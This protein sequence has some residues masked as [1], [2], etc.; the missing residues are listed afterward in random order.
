[1]TTKVMEDNL[2][3][4]QLCHNR[5]GDHGKQSA[6]KGD[7]GYECGVFSISQAEDGAV[8]G[9]RHGDD[10][11]VDV[12]HQRVET[13]NAED[14]I[15]D[16]WED[17]QPE[18][19]GGIYHSRTEHRVPGKPR[20]RRTYDQQ[21]SRHGDVAYHGDGLTDDFWNVVN[22]QRHNQDGKIGCNHW[23]AD[24]HLGLERQPLLF[25]IHQ[26]HSYGKDRE[27]VYYIENGGI[28]YCLVAEN[29]IHYGV[30]Y[31][32]YISEHQGEPHRPSVFNAMGEKPW[33]KPCYDRKQ[34]IGEEADA[35]Q[36][37]DET[38]VRERPSHC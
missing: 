11:G 4:E 25:S 16:K 24:Q 23:R 22:T 18:D 17:E 2:S 32:T 7:F 38:T 9:N 10:Q 30:S 34:E 1:M 12:D 3:H 19:G 35:Q 8:S 26:H 14:G 33:E 6:Y 37:Q 20:H 28:E 36:R 31:E 27:G 29:S 5:D 13:K 15:Q 21:C